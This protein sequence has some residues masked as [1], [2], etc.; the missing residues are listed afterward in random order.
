[1]YG[2]GVLFITLTTQKISIELINFQTTTFRDAFVQRAA[3]KEKILFKERLDEF[4]IT[5]DKTWVV[6]KEG[7]KKNPGEI[8]NERFFTRQGPRYLVASAMTRL[9]SLSNA[10]FN[11]NVK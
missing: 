6:M 10:N 9:L 1:M 8:H 11:E 2:V 3:E 4:E 5:L 7:M